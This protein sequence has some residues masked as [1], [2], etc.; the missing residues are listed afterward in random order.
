M[1]HAEHTY[2]GFV[3][4]IS[5]QGMTAGQLRDQILDPRQYHA[6]SPSVLNLITS[7]HFRS[8]RVM[9]YIF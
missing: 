5:K 7:K 6:I 9:L 4:T 2:E 8:M 1:K 3:S